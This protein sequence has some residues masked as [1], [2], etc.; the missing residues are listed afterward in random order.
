MIV[1]RYG[2][3]ANYS[4]EGC[5]QCL[6]SPVDQDYEGLQLDTRVGIPEKHLHGAKSQAVLDDDL[7][8]HR[9]GVTEKQSHEAFTTREILNSPEST[10]GTGTCFGTYVSNTHGTNNY[11]PTIS[12]S[13]PG[14]SYSGFEKS[15]SRSGFTPVPEAAPEERRICGLRILHFRILAGLTLFLIIASAV[16]GGVIGGLQ[17][18]NKH[19]SQSSA[20]ANST[21]SPPVFP[22]AQ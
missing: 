15:N 16:I 18:E 11:G 13:T 4:C 21:P 12:P 5:S 20:P 7:D 22:Q 19:G 10:C 9:K 3:N 6:Q 17:A 2:W 14:M 8:D 1:R